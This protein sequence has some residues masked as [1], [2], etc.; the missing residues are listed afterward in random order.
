MAMRLNLLH[1][2]DALARQPEFLSACARLGATECDLRDAGARI[3]LWADDGD[4]D[5][6]REALRTSLGGLDGDGTI[7]TWMGSGDFHHVTALLLGLIAGQR[8]PLT[9]VQFDNHPDWACQP[10]G[11][12]C[13]S[14][15][16]RVLDD[17]IVERVVTIGANS[18]D[19]RWPDLKRAGL[20]HLAEGRQ[21]LFPLRPLRLS[22]MSR[23]QRS[24][25]PRI[26]RIS[27]ASGCIGA[28]FD[29]DTAERVLAAIGAGSVYV[30]IDKDVLAGGGAATNWDQG[31]LELDDLTRW[32]NLLAANRRFA[33]VDVTGDYSRPVYAGPWRTRLRKRAEAILDQP[34]SAPGTHGPRANER[35]NLHLLGL[36]GDA[37]C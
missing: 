12:H 27:S 19:L 36:L 30:T 17:G 18:C 28:R 1:L 34:W 8:G 14:W 16:R 20:D 11:I 35:T 26:A 32:L 7:V 9:V 5:A 3:R 4:L 31:T 10:N 24:S 6:L 21:V 25:S 33:G 23:R 37:L 29:A 13:G 2:D 22:P 15:V